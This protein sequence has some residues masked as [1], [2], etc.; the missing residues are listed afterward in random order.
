MKTAAFSCFCLANGTMFVFCQRYIFARTADNVEDMPYVRADLEHNNA[1]HKKEFEMKQA[2]ICIFDGCDAPTYFSVLVT[3]DEVKV[4]KLAHNTFLNGDE[5]TAEQDLAVSSVLAACDEHRQ[6]WRG[7]ALLPGWI[8][9]GWC[10]RKL[11]TSK[12]CVLPEKAALVI[13][14][15]YA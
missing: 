7:V 12:I 8:D 9:K 6:N 3:A 10:K 15:C 13:T 4:L 14:G 1:H 5:L 2:L 11:D